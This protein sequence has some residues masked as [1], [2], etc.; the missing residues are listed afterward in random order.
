VVPLTTTYK[1]DRLDSTM[2]L[3]EISQTA[4]GLYIG[5]TYIQIG[6]CQG[7]ALKDEWLSH[8]LMNYYILVPKE[9]ERLIFYTC[10]VIG[11]PPGIP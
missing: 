8:D 4:D 3:S 2:T 5:L 11:C 1:F 10:V 7:I 6:P 9:P